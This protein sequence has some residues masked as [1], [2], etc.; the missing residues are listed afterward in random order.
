[1]PLA[2]AWVVS[3]AMTS[4]ASKPSTSTWRIFRAS[5][6]SC[7]SDTWPLN[8]VGVAE[9]PALYSEYSSV[10]NV[11]RDTSKATPTWVGCSSRR[12]LM[13]MEVKP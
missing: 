12:T 7:S 2:A 3:V 11:L 8:S 5:S 4:S 6:T 1:M 10:R 13:S 9:R